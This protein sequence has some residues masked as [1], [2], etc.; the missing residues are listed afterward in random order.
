V[1]LWGN[2]FLIL[3]YGGGTSWFVGVTVVMKARIG[4]REPSWGS[5]SPTRI[6]YII[7]TIGKSPG[8]R[9]ACRRYTERKSDVIL[10]LHLNQIRSRLSRRIMRRSLM[11][12]K[13]HVHSRRLFEPGEISAYHFSADQVQVQI[14]LLHPFI[15][16]M[17]R[18]CIK[19]RTSSYPI[20]GIPV[21]ASHTARTRRTYRRVV[22]SRR[23]RRG[24][25][26]R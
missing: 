26:G 15:S 17:D 18:P 5:L 25:Q 3:C 13:E 22:Q 19:S 21:S 24:S 20:P 9:V 16:R 12:T 4:K 6:G 10:R 23:P 2:F 8:Q 14:I 7:H 1:Q 11:P